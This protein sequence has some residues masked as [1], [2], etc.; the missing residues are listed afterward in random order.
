MIIMK[1]EKNCLGAAIT[2]ALVSQASIT[3][4]QIEEVLIT[5]TKHSESA[6][7]VPVAVA[8]INE[9]KLEQLAVNTFSDYLMQLPGVTSGGSGPG[10]S[11]IYIRGIASTTPNLTTAGVAGLA[12]NVAFYLD[13][14]PL[15]QPGRNLDVYAADMSRIEVLAGPQGTLFGASSQA[16]TVRL[17]TNKPDTTENYGKL[18][19]G[20]S[21]IDGGETNYNIEAMYNVALSDDL[22][23]RAVVYQDHQGG[24]IDNV[25]GERDISESARFRTEGT[26]RA[27][28][29]P[30]SSVR[31][32]FQAGANLS[33]ITM[34][35][36]DN[37]AFVEDNIND[38]DYT[39]IRVSAS[40]DINDDWN[41]L[42]SYAH[43]D[44]DSD[45][46]F[47]EDEELDDYEIQRFAEDSLHDSFDSTAWTLT[48]MVGELELVYTGAFT[49][50]EADQ[51]IDYTDYMFVGQYLPYYIC[52]Y[53]VVYP[54]SGDPTGHC[55]A[56]NLLVDSATHTK[57][58]THEIRI[59]TDQ[60]NW[61]RATTGLFYSDLTLKELNDFNYPGS[62]GVDGGLGWVPN[63]SFDTGYVSDR[64]AYPEGVIFRND[65]RR[66]DEQYGIFGEFTADINDQWSITFGARYY[67]VTVDMDGS[68]NSSFCN[69]ALFFDKDSNAFGTDIS[70][71]YNNDGAYTLRDCTD[72]QTTYY[73]DDID[74][75]TPANVVAAL[76]A[77]DAAK[78]SGT[79]LKGTL[80]WV[81][82]DDQLYYLTV[83]EG[84]RPGLLN[85]PGGASNGM[86]YTVPYALDTDEV[87]NIELG[88]KIDLLDRSMRFNGNIFN[89][90]IDRMQTTIFDP[91]IT[92]LFFSDNA[93]NAEV[94]GMEGD[95]TW[96]PHSI[97]GLY[98]NFAFSL[99]DSEVTDVL[100]PTSDVI[101]GN[102][103]AYAPE[104]QFTTTLRYEW[105][106]GMGLSAHVMGQMIYADNS[107]TDIITINRYEIDEW[108]MF[109]LT[110]G[111]QNDQW[112]AELFIDN[113]SNER[114][115][116]AGSFYFDRARINYA[117]PRT[118]GLR[119]ALNF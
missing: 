88:W 53:S 14:H 8:A 111:V 34:G 62:V 59:S 80:N 98:F 40:W 87:V 93:A 77:P 4:A 20:V 45:G 113:V 84:Y 31:E 100:I 2:L 28:G 119:F 55:G 74:A 10:Q 65:V 63:Y 112:K 103:L 96:M 69:R 1:L 109:G 106:A 22:A 70:D 42:V 38:T 99:L 85:R 97:A 25:A 5:A 60:S 67:D 89:A 81:P 12:P 21:T 114:A 39:G 52:D 46:V 48:G 108:T 3:N 92:N 68:A 11:T 61:I 72:P 102:S 30:V 51:I 110:G 37:S 116:T 24:Y 75:S 57:T 15:A 41:L 6:Q 107:Y 91:S 23:I 13:E 36:A 16:G 56:P 19:L 83:S 66:T 64:N 73:E 18:K 50:R 78:T 54:G 95:F 117:P 9:E 35:V 29:V 105:D 47:F 118:M 104:L 82:I 115:Q 94:T 27:N 43:Q 26:V 79:I 49:K 86:G 101:K 17:I 58:S 7:D 71:L 76:N 90:R 33:G 44:I 32:G